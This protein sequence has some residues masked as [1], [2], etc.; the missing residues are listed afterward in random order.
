MS[1]YELQAVFEEA[2]YH[3]TLDDIV[4]L[5]IKY[6]EDK[7]TQEI[8]DRLLRIECIMSPPTEVYDYV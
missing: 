3:Q 5:I 8:H 4:D 6:G 2:H 7:I 1:N